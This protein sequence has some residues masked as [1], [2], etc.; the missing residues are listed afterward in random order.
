VALSGDGNTALIGGPVDNGGVGTAWV[1]TRSGS[2]WTQQGSKLTG[3]DETEGGF[4]GF[5]VA[6][7]GDGNTALIGGFTTT[8]AAVRRGCSRTG[9]R[10]RR[11]RY[12]LRAPNRMSFGVVGGR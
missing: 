2:T 3:T 11:L 12:L 7:S 5:S 6:L 1:F 9:P 4:F 10:P 8:A